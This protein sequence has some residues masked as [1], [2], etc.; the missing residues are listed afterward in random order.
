MPTIL[1][2]PPLEVT[3][4]VEL[5]KLDL[6]KKLPSKKLDENLLIASWNIRAFGDLT[7]KW[8]SE[9]IDSP[10][11]DLHAVLCISEIIKRF[12]VIAIQEVKANI[13]AL[14][15]TLKVLGSHWSLVL[16][17][18]NKGDA[19]NGERMAYLFDTR[20]VQLS[21]LA[22]ELVVPQ[23]WLN[24][25]SQDALTEQFVRSPYAVSFKSNQ[26]TFI[27][28]TLHIL[29]GKKSKDRIKELKGIAKWLSDWSKDI[30]AYHQNII[31]LGDFN[32]DK[33]GDLLDET[34]LSE[35]L[36]VPPQLQNNNVT[37]S[38]F[39][40]TKYYD[41]IAWFNG[42]NNKPR[43]TMD[44]INGGNFDFIKTALVNRDLSKQSL[45][46]FISDHYPLWAEFKL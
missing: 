42:K 26:Q 35:G 21:G 6:N 5:L 46:F 25:V 14:R 27:L 23:E 2:Q 37:R 32:I 30:N 4:N 33:R 20:R 22:G 1:D 31:V 16:T 17:D 8:E 19:G 36:F 10:K 13:R 43:L 34:F 7:R 28:V 9:S 11:R 44:F 18:V 3:R 40:K 12:D 24:T 41:Q 29:Y 45:S 38:I 15:D 39:N